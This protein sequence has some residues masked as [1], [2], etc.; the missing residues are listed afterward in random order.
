MVSRSSSSRFMAEAPGAARDAGHWV[1]KNRPARGCRDGQEH[2]ALHGVIELA[3]VAGPFVGAPH[4]TPLEKPASAC[5]SGPTSAQ[6]VLGQRQNVLTPL[7]QRREIELDRVEPEERSSRKRPAS[8]LGPRSTLVAAM[9]RTLT[10]RVRD[11]PTRSSSPVCSTRSNR[12]CWASGDVGHLVEEQRASVGQLEASG[13]IGLGVGERPPHV[14]EELA[15]EHS[16]G[17]PAHV[18]DDRTVPGACSRHGSSGPRLLSR[19]RALR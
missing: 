16:L 6:E 1:G 15:L 17:E 13:A 4:G 7:A 14:A 11:E 18:H 9:N 5:H 19:C 12:A 10:R 8:H 2:R 3:H